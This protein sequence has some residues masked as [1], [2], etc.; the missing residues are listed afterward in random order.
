MWQQPC[1]RRSSPGLRVSK[2]FLDKL[3]PLITEGQRLIDFGSGTGKAAAPFLQAGLCVDMVDIASNALDPE[4]QSLLHILPA[5]LSFTQ[6]PLWNLPKTLK[7]A[8]WIYCCDVLEH[9]PSERVMD[10]LREMSKRTLKG[11]IFQIYLEDEPFGDMIGQTLHLTL[12][13]REWWIHQIAKFWPI[14]VVSPPLKNHVRLAVI[15]G[16]G[17]EAH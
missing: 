6:S 12:R 8:E 10:T 16:K 14:R 5:H 1:Y 13:P 9:I 15:V 11:G 17:Y 2:L 4:M 7:P 3:H